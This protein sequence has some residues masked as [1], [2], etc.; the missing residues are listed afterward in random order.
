MAYGY[1][2]NSG[3]IGAIAIGTDVSAKYTN[4]W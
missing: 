2:A 1:N 4:R 3:G